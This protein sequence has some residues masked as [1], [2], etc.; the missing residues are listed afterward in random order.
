MSISKISRSAL[1]GLDVRIGRVVATPITE[2]MP[3][4]V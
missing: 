3:A 1:A 4:G 2:P